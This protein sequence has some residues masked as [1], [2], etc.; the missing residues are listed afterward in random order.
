MSKPFESLTFA[1]GPSMKNRYMLAPLTNLQS[2]EDGTLSDDEFNW[3]RLRAVGGFGLTMTCAAH[4]QAA[5]RGFRGQLGIFSDAHL[6]GLE[7]LAS[8]IRREGSLSSVQ[9]FHGG[10][11]APEKVTG[12]T[13]MCPSVNEEFHARAMSAGEVEQVIEDFILAAERADKAGFDGVE[14]HGAH[15]YILC[16]FLS[17]EVNLRDDAWGGSLDNRARPLFDVIKG[18]RARCRADFQIGVRLS[19]ERYG[20]NL[21]EVREI[22]QRLMRLGTVDY[23]DMSLWDIAKAPEDTAFQGRSLMSCFTELERGSC[24]LGVAGK[25][26]RPQDVRM[27]L[28][29]G[30]DFVLLGRAAILHHDYPARAAAGDFEPATL[31][32]SRAHLKA[33][34]LGQAF[35]DYMATWPKFVAD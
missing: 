8:A 34:G 6:P 17:S 3:L 18:V 4:V 25:I 2:H 13:P 7:R 15:G 11:R 9:L 12:L 19:P 29:A 33:E 24:R 23:I 16:Q 28:D 21:G 31:P 27:A 10:M 22:A 30:C 5:G 20:M 35:I 32:I 26:M 14:L 1:H